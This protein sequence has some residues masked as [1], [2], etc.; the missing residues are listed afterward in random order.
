MRTHRLPPPPSLSDPA[1]RGEPPAEAPG[2]SDRLG[3]GARSPEGGKVRGPAGG[4]GHASSP[5]DG[6]HAP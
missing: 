1:V 3:G 2:E 4:G 6:P 5:A